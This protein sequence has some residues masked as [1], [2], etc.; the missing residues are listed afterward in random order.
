MIQEEEHAGRI[1]ELIRDVRRLIG[2]EKEMVE[3]LELVNALRQLGV[4]YHF[5]EEIMDVMSNISASMDE[6]NMAIEVELC[7]TALL[8]R[9]LREH[10]FN[11]SQGISTH[12]FESFTLQYI[13]AV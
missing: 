5:E 3:Q 11:A 10:G 7:T 4:A 8:F 1:E 6:I 2:E 13:E 9:L 12:K